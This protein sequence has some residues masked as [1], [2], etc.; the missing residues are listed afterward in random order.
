MTGFL[1]YSLLMCGG[2]PSAAVKNR[3]WPAPDWIQSPDKPSVE[4][5]EIDEPDK[6]E[7]VARNLGKR[8]ID[9]SIDLS[10]GTIWPN[11]L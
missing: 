6:V 3:V 4:W 8:L 10:I 5:R 2:L 9:G 11:Q 7:L 1:D